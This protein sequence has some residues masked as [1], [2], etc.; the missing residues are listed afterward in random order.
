MMNRLRT[1]IYGTCVAAALAGA[2]P[3][4]RAQRVDTT[5]TQPAG[6]MDSAF[7]RA[8]ALVISGQTAAGR[9]IV[10]SIFA[11][12]PVGTTA[13]GDALYGRAMVA[14]TAAAAAQ[15]YR[16]IVVEYPLSMHAGDALLQLAQIER[17]EGDR[18][19]A[20]GHLERFLRENP[21]SSKRARTG[22]WLAQLYFE[23][24]EDL[25]A[26]GI[27]DEARNAIPSGDVELENQMNFYR[28]RCDAAAARARADSV[29]R[30]DSLRA[31]SVARADS[32]RN[33]ERRARARA[34][35]E[36][37]SKSAPTSTRSSASSTGAYSVQVGAFA[38]AAEAEKVVA[39][40]HARGLEARVDGTRKPFRVRIGRYKTRGEA[41]AAL[42]R[43]KK[44]GINGFVTSLDER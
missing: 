31:D 10:D 8:R 7:A 34:R 13:Y 6:A 23:Q 43:L 27:L 22:L 41:T 1:M 30:A 44:A 2:A 40:L 12:T 11:A 26:C 15:D 17:S 4:I 38:T 37:A 39:R 14:P 21:A 3:S 9:K 35:T 5:A 29:A 18:A 25:N 24:N 36:P 20:I 42:T 32:I 33:A 19:S 16:R 28:P